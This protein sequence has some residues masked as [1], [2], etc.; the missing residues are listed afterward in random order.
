MQIV[1]QRALIKALERLLKEA[2]QQIIK[3][4]QKVAQDDFIVSEQI[5]QLK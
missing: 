5:C 3:L 1:N 4:S 2:H